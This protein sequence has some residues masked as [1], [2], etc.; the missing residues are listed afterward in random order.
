[1][2]VMNN[3]E[4]HYWSFKLSNETFSDEGY[5]FQMCKRAELHPADTLI[6]KVE[7]FSDSM[8]LCGLAFYDDLM[9][10]VSKVGLT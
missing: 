3:A 5:K 4:K 10:L 8:G 1:M 6:K 9:E 7:I 2:T